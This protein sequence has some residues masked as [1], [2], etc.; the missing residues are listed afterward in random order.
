MADFRTMTAAPLPVIVN[1]SGGTARRAGDELADMLKTAFR[2]AGRE[3]VLELVEGRDIPAALE[4]HADAPRVAVGGGDGTLG[5]A[6]GAIARRGGELAVLP[7]GTRNHFAGQLG[8]PADLPAAAKLAAHGRARA[9]DLG[10]ANGRTFINNFSVGAYVDL[11]RAREH[12]RL[13]K[14]LATV[15]A[16]WRTLR[17]L[18]SRPFEL[19]VDGA[20]RTIE[21]PLLFVGNN[22][23]KVRDGRPGEREALDDGL[24]DC[25]AVASLSRAALI[26]T[27]LRTL[28]ARPRMHRD[29]VLDCTATELRI[30]GPGHALDAALDGERVRFD[31]PLAI[32]ICPR[33][34]SVVAPPSD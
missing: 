18:R 17:K 29:F 3:I 9:A 28:I 23:Y 21:T 33:A 12:S 34:L 2:D 32:R 10:E 19:E 14:L 22:R 6:A 8:V 5:G 4:R 20:R 27:A 25:Y 16:T 1:T 24:L 11:V 26:A 15:P 30:E 13:P 7:L 31:L